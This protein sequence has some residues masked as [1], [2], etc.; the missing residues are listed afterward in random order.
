MLLFLLKRLICRT[1][2]IVRDLDIRFDLSDKDDPFDFPTWKF[3]LR[4]VR[5]LQDAI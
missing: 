2:S 4:T 1:E 5:L 3:E